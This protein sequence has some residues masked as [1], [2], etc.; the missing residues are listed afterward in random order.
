MAG[1][2]CQASSGEGLL[3]V[4]SLAWVKNQKLTIP[5]LMHMVIHMI[6]HKPSL[7]VINPPSPPKKSKTAE[8][9]NGL[10][11]LATVYPI[12][13]ANPSHMPTTQEEKRVGGGEGSRADKEVVRGNSVSQ[14]GAPYWNV[15]LGVGGV[16]GTGTNGRVSRSGSVSGSI[17]NANASSDRD[18]LGEEGSI[19]EGD[20][21]ANCKSREEFPYIRILAALQVRRPSF[22]PPDHLLSRFSLFS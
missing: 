11:K 10:P 22:Y 3:E 9:S 13:A 4:P 19:P 6:T 8:R 5:K 14:V 15:N 12:P 20:K 1:R 21:D 7:Q 16:N 2:V 18:G 17:R